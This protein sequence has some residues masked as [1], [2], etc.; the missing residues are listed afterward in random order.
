[1]PN[2]TRLASVLA[3]G[4]LVA[5]GCDLNDMFHDLDNPRTL[6]NVSV[7][8][9][10]TAEAGAFPDRGGEGEMRTFET[11]EGWTIALVSAYFTTASVTLHGCDGDEVSLD[12]YWG[13]LAEDITGRDLDMLTVGGVEVDASE[14]CTLDV[15]YGPYPDSSNMNGIDERVAGATFYLQGAATKGDVV[16]PFEIRSTEAFDA[17]LDMSTIAAGK[18]LRVDGGEDFPVELA[19]S[20]TYDRIF[21]GLDF[22]TAS[23]DDL[24]AQVGA[25]LALESRVALDRV[26]P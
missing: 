12:M 22:E 9:H 15:H 14:F 3:L 17:S 7:T 16:V 26:A 2:T 5:G 19:L 21:D 23:Q 6:I 20:K 24:A 10:A 25:V 13:P 4:A 11:D 1:M 18:P 8:H